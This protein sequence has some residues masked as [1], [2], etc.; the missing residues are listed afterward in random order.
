MKKTLFLFAICFFSNGVFSQTSVFELNQEKARYN[1]TK[2]IS[3]IVSSTFHSETLVTSSEF[4]QITALMVQKDGY[5]SCTLN[6]QNKLIV[7]H[8]DWVQIKD[9]EDVI[10]QVVQAHVFDPSKEHIIKTD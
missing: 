2:H 8:E 1:Q 7:E 4:S 6:A 3:T 5:V 9:I 10:G